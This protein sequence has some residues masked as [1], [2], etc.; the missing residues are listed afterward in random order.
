MSSGAYDVE[1]EIIDKQIYTTFKFVLADSYV[2]GGGR[3][4]HLLITDDKPTII[5]KVKPKEFFY[6]MKDEVDQYDKTGQFVDRKKALE[7]W[8]LMEGYYPPKE[9]NTV[10]YFN[11]LKQKEKNKNKKDTGD[12]NKDNSKPRGRKYKQ[13]FY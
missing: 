7:I 4:L 2:S 10:A 1:N 3:P 9:Y 6:Y 13:A 8:N 11:D 5:G 12:E